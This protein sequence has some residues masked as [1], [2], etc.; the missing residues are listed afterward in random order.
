MG[1]TISFVTGL[2]P[3]IFYSITSTMFDRLSSTT[4]RTFSKTKISLGKFRSFY[5][6]GDLPCTIR[7]IARGQTLKCFV[8]DFE[9]LNID[10]YLP[11]FVDGLCETRYPYS[12]I[13]VRGLERDVDGK[14]FSLFGLRVFWI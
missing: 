11:I 8:N 2:C 6:R 7:H 13:G 4:Y 9:C 14:R 10:Y 3:C 1:E 12:F 5:E